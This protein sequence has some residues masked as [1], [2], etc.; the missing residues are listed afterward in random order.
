[1][2]SW[3][4]DEPDISAMTRNSVKINHS[5]DALSFRASFPDRA[6]KERFRFA[7]IDR[8]DIAPTNFLPHSPALRSKRARQRG[9]SRLARALRNRDVLGQGRVTYAS[10][11]GIFAGVERHA[12][13][14][15]ARTANCRWCLYAAENVTL[16]LYDFE[17]DGMSEPRP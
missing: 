8:C 11:S 9:A 2:Q 17:S 7:K 14:S 3:P 4:E 1:M 5:V 10:G 15:S 12:D 13:Y 16:N 6:G